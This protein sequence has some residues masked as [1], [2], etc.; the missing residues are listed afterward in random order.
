MFLT[1][2]SG[3]FAIG[4]AR[5]T[6][7]TEFL[8]KIPTS[9]ASLAPTRVTESGSAVSLR[10]PLWLPFGAK[11]VGVDDLIVAA[12]VD[13]GQLT[14][15]YVASWRRMLA[16]NTALGCVFI[17]LAQATSAPLGLS[18]GGVALLAW[19][20][21]VAYWAHSRRLR[22]FLQHIASESTGVVS[23]A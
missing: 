9:V 11:V 20:I 15:S 5:P 23:A 22:K 19:A 16:I 4:D 7:A 2:M 10:L 18:I 12:T 13:S 21:G 8:A 14:V 6:S 17:G 3:C 1:K